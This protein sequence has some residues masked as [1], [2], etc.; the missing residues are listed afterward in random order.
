MSSWVDAPPP[1]KRGMGCFAKGCLT[2]LALI[3]L[4]ATAFVAGSYWAVRHLRESYSATASTPLPSAPLAADRIE[5]VRAQWD[6]FTA[7]AEQHRRA[8]IELNAEEVNALIASEPD[9]RGKAFVSIDGDVGHAQLSI[10]IAEIAWLKGRYLNGAC[11]I[12]PSPNREPADAKITEITLMGH[13]VPDDVL[14]YEMFGWKSIRTVIAAWCAEY[15]LS[16]FE[17]ADGKV[18]LETRGQ[19]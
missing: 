8:R 19:E 15:N 9:W 17:I 7:A 1:Q 11:T 10:P 6:V 3:I 2:L 4:L 14:D 18:V 13:R 5:Q 16:L 12:R